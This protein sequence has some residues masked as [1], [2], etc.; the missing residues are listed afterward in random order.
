MF[1]ALFLSLAMAASSQDDPILVVDPAPS[2]VI[3]LAPYDLG[4]PG[5]VDQLNHRIV[6]SAKLVCEHGYRG[7]GYRETVACVQSA[8]ADGK[9]QLGRLLSQNPNNAAL[10]GTI[11]I[12]TPKK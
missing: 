12:V 10:T 9:G 2:I 8:I 7:L 5:D 3:S 4:K 1:T 11:A 6:T